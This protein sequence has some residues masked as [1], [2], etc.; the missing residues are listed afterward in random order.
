MLGIALGLAGAG[1]VN[2]AAP[3]LAATVGQSNGSHSTVSVHLVAT[4]SLTV[5]VAAAVLALA[6]RLIAGGSGA[7][8]ATRLRP[9]DAFQQVE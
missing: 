1:I 7:W 3:K 4:V 2:A 8:R 9:A 5:V 6:G